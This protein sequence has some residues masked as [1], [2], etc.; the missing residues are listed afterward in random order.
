M[1]NLPRTKATGDIY[2][3]GSRHS[4]RFALSDVHADSTP[5]EVQR[6]DGLYDFLSMPTYAGKSG[7]ESSGEDAS[8]L[9]FLLL[10][11]FR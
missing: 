1:N 5:I 9:G 6:A 11:E 2:I 4:Q 3:D 7:R 10:G 8:T